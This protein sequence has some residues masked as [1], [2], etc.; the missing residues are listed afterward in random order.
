MEKKQ[1]KA[2][3]E[4]HSAL[5]SPLA[6]MRD[7]ALKRV[8]Q[9][10]EISTVAELI[11]LRGETDEEGVRREGDEV[12]R[13]VWRRACTTHNPWVFPTWGY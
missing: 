13:G 2:L 7:A 9:E 4:L 11:R 12:L 3:A 5:H 10:G 1:S 6:E 8:K